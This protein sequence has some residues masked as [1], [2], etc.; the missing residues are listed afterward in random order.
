MKKYDLIIVGGGASGMLCAIEAKKAGIDNVL[1]IEKDN[2]LG[3]ALSLGNYNISNKSEITGKKY[4]ECIVQEFEKYNIETRFNTMVIKIEENNQVLCTSPT[5]GIEKISGEKIILANG[6]K[7]GSR[8]AVRMVGNRCAGIYTVGM[9]KKI[10]AMNMIPGKK[11]LIDGAN[12]LYMIEKE[13]KNSNVEVV[14]IISNEENINNYGLTEN[15]YNNY[16][17]SHI[18]G[19]GRVEKV[20]LEKDDETIFIQCDS[21]IFAK[22]Q[23]SDGLVAMRSGIKLNPN[24]TG[25]EVDDKYMTSME[26]V[27]A[28]GNGI[29]IHKYIEDIEEEC[30]QLITKIYK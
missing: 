23:L 29:Y 8:K 18:E 10:F 19:K 17:I 12:T 22:G 11:V 27:Y 28:C 5:N 7:E 3:G 21:I 1:L 4:K 20:A 30:S 16:E 13:L 15:I 24:T 25:P 2:E 26:N 6:A 14:G 9:A